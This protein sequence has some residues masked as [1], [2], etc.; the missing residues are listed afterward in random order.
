MVPGIG[1]W[2]SGSCSLELRS[3]NSFKKGLGGQV[4]PPGGEMGGAGIIKCWSLKMLLW[5]LFI[6]VCE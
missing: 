4:D 2:V 3:G 5:H 6:V 1:Y